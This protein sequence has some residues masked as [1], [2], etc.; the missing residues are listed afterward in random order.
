MNTVPVKKLLKQIISKASLIICWLFFIVLT[1]C[2]PSA[3]CYSLSGIHLGMSVNEV[4]SLYKIPFKTYV[5]NRKKF[6]L[7]S[8]EINGWQLSLTAS[9]H[10]KGSRI[11]QIFGSSHDNHEALWKKF[12]DDATNSCGLPEKKISIKQV[13]ATKEIVFW[14]DVEI[15]PEVGKYG[16][17]STKFESKGLC[18][19]GSHSTLDNGEG[20]CEITIKD[21]ESGV[22]F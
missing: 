7:G 15:L 4:N 1:R 14:G 19:V 16:S 10:E 21:S 5:L 20:Y 2:N 11:I 8:G 22:E 12:Q 9:S 13:G 6:F 18:I 3:S 17:I